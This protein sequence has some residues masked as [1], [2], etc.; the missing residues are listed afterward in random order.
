MEEIAEKRFRIAFLSLI[1]LLGG[2]LRFAPTLLSGKVINDG[3]MFFSMVQDV[4]ESNFQLPFTVIYNGLDIPFAYPPLPFYLTAL[5]SQFFGW[6]LIELF[7]WLPALFST[8]SILAFYLTAKTMLRSPDPALLATAGFAFIP[9]AYTWFVMGG[10]ISRA[11]GQIFLLLTI[12]S[13]YKTFTGKQRKH[14]FL[15]A[16]FGALV[17]V[18]HPGQSLHTIIL[19]T[20]LWLYLDWK[21]F[22][23]ALTIALGVALL[24]SPWWLTVIARH[25]FEPFLSAA[26]TG[27]VSGFFWIALVFPTFAEE[28]LLTIFTIFAIMGFVVIM[29]RRDFLLVLFLVLP[30]LFDPRTAPSISIIPLAMLSG[31]GLND[32]VLPGVARMS[33]QGVSSIT[34]NLEHGWINQFVRFRSVRW[35]LGYFL[36]LSLL[37]GYAY[38]QPLS[39]MTLPDTSKE[40]MLWIKENTPTNSAFLILTGIDDPFGDPVQEW[41]PVFSERVSISTIQGKEWLLGKNFLSHVGELVALQGCLNAEPQCIVQTAITNG[42]SF[43]YLYLQKNRMVAQDNHTRNPGLLSYLLRSSFAYDL[44]YENDDVEIFEVLDSPN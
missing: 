10:G 11:L 14:V 6:P 8:L 36:F 44:V 19:C 43:N 17:V 34:G 5:C 3:G 12:W 27:G 38:D 28:S 23:R 41:F 25:G 42:N 32:L 9:R 15:C 21:A 33:R 20:C 26:Q 24:S 16:L 1:V 31:V 2:W 22:G 18:S 4:L 39:R 7:R 30:F 37:G 40:A 29:L 35:V 13:A